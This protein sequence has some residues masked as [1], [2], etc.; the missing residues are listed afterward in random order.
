MT[1]GRLAEEGDLTDILRRHGGDVV[2][3]SVRGLTDQLK[4]KLLTVDFARA[5][6]NDMTGQFRFG[7]DNSEECSRR[8]IQLLAESGAVVDEFKIGTASLEEVF[9]M[10][11]GTNAN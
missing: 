8:L 6:F 1:N 9:R 10:V 5:E 11:V 7:T 3:L 4:I 2:Q